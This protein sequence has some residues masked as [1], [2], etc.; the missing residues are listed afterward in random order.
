MDYSAFE[1]VDLPNLTVTEPNPAH[2]L[3]FRRFSSDQ[4]VRFN[5]AQT[6]ILRRYTKAPLIHNYMGREMAFDHF[7]VG[8]DLDVASWDSYPLGFLSD[9]LEGSDAHKA[10]YLRQGDPDFQAFHHDLYRAVGKGRWWIMEQQPGPVNW[11][12]FNPAPL[13]GMVRLWSW[14]AFAHGAETVTYFRWGQL[15]FAQAQMHA[16]L[17]RPDGEPAPALAEA[18]QVAEE[19]KALPEVGTHR[20]RVALVFDYA[21]AWA[22]ETQPQ[23]ADFDYFRLTFAYYRALRSLGLSIDILPADCGDLTAY[24]LVLIPGLLNLSAPLRNAIERSDAHI[25]AGPRTNSKTDQLSITLPLPPNLPGLN[26]TVT[27]V[28]SLPPSETIALKEAGHMHHWFEHVE[29]TDIAEWTETGQPAVLGSERLTYLCGWPDQTAL[30]RIL[31]SIADQ[32]GLE[33]WD[34]PEGLRVRDTDTHRFVFNYA[35]YAQEWK[36]IALPPAGVHWEDLP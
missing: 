10:T 22:W 6:D 29:A 14:E 23:G 30:T 16:A 34:L 12:P 4:V 32:R 2:V 18:K 17:L 31:K 26:A 3:A 11:A 8:Q 19:I 21:S 28:E 1:D 5:K 9:R 24:D 36:G 20:A 33:T 27:H 35:P 7:A 25:L 15:P 13:P